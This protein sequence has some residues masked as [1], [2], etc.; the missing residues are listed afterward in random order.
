MPDFGQV[1]LDLDLGDEDDEAAPVSQATPRVTAPLTGRPPESDEAT[2]IVS[3]DALSYFTRSQPPPPAVGPSGSV[4]PPA[5]GSI[6]PTASGITPRAAGVARLRDLYAR[7]DV[8]GALAAA[9]TVAENA[10]FGSIDVDL[11]GLELTPRETMLSGRPLALLMSRRGIPRL[12]KPAAE[13]AH[14]PIDHRAGFL[15]AHVDG[16]QSM[17]EIL[18]VCAMPEA[19]ALAHLERLLALGVIEIT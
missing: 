14:L 8:E 5:P 16:R 3:G 15:L 17:E 11:D 18:D 6:R 10:E 1:D 2:R 4:P 19:E 7:G 13:I 12:L 9:S